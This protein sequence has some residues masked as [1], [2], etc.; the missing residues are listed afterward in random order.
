MYA[1][2]AETGKEAW[3]FETEAEIHA[4][5][6]VWTDPETKTQHIIIG[7]YDYNVYSLDA[8]TGKKEWAAETGYYINGGAAVGDGKVVFGG[9]DSVLHVPDWKTGKEEK[10]CSLYTYGAHQE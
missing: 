7:S 4:A 3:K 8:K 6:N 9:C 2:N 1:W 10:H 5:A